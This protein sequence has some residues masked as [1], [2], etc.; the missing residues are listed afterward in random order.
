MQHPA[1]VQHR[2]GT[3]DPDAGNRQN[4]YP[5]LRLLPRRFYIDPTI[6]EEELERV[7]G[8][9]W[10]FL[11]HVSQ[12]PGKGDYFIEDLCGE[13]ILVVRG[14]D[15]GIRAF[16]NHCRHRGHRLCSSVT[17]NARTF[18]CPYHQWTYG[19]DGSLVR[20]PGNKDGEVFDYRDWGLHAVRVEVWH[21]LIFGWLSEVEGPSLASCLAFDD[22]PFR[23]LEAGRVKEIHRESY[24][25]E[26]NW[27]I[28]LENYLECYHC[29]GSHP[30]LCVTM[31]VQATYANTGG[32]WKRQY[33]PGLLQL[34]PGMKTGSMDGSLVSK[35]L[36][37]F[38]ASAELPDGYGAGF[39]I[40]PSL[41]RVIFHVDHAIVHAMRPIDVSHVRWQTFWYVRD[42]AE[43]GVDYD[44]ERVTE[45]WRLTN[46]EDISLCEGAFQGVHSRR[47]VSGPLDPV[48]EAAIPAALET[49][50]ELMQA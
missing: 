22:T 18:T 34:R 1:S 32:D 17:G 40:V 5:E 20:A 25:I 6:Y 12:I 9:Q 14:Q 46:K 16:L 11:G 36:G 35:P 44:V 31:D 27:K 37:E 29:L 10:Q 3:A 2:N 43:E 23:R 42:D 19:L 28:L 13:S 47:F 45:L 48:R 24:D 41:T 4:S 33:F 26:A 49:Y 8:R 7:F 38:A 50:R 30:E 39:G 21:G 15:E